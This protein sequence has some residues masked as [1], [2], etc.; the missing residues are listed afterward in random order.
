M[1]ILFHAG[2]R[3][4]RVKIIFVSMKNQK[5]YTSTYIELFIFVVVVWFFFVITAFKDGSKP[6]SCIVRLYAV[7]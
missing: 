6:L 1:K 2:L 5:H 3:E 7:I 4:E